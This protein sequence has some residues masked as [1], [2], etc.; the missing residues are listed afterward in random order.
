[1]LKT[2]LPKTKPLLGELYVK[3]P[4]IWAGHTRTLKSCVLLPQVPTQASV[5]LSVLNSFVG[6]PIFIYFDLQ[7]DNRFWGDILS[8]R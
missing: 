4:S 8:R 2:T 7:S 1:M 6:E 3:N 5:R